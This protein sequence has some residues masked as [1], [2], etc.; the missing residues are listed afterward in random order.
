MAFVD[1]AEFIAI[2]KTGA[3]ILMCYSYFS[4]DLDLECLARSGA[5]FGIC[6]LGLK[7]GIYLSSVGSSG[8]SA[9]PCCLFGTLADSGSLAL[10][11]C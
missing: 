5:R 7:T 3:F 1:F 9:L 11:R 2:I 8:S 10:G 4:L 6:L